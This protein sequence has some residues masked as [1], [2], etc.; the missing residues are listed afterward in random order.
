MW[1]KYGYKLLESLICFVLLTFCF[2]FCFC[3]YFFTT[4]NVILHAKGVPY[5]LCKISMFCA[6]SQ[7]YQHLLEKWYMHLI[8]NSPRNSKMVLKLVGQAVFKLWIKIFKMLFGS[9][10][11][12]LLAYLNFYVI[13]EFLWQFTLRCIHYFSKRCQ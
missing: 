9:I 8:V 7:N 2:V 11:Q 10:T 13:F 3:F 4:R 12:E 1:K 6:L 5:C